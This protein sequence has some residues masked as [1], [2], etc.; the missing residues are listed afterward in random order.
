MKN[1]FYF[2]VAIIILIVVGC[3]QQE[4]SWQEA[5]KTNT[6]MAYSNYLKL[7]S[8]GEHITEAKNLI[9][10]LEWDSAFR[11]KNDSL[12]KYLILKYPNHNNL[13]KTNENIAYLDNLKWKIEHH[14]IDIDS[15]DLLV[16]NSGGRIIAFDG[17]AI[18]F[19]GP[20]SYVK[21]HNIE[22]ACR[23]KGF[24]KVLIWRDFSSD[25][26]A[27]AKKNGL[28]TGVAYLQ[29]VP[30]RYLPIRKVDLKKS[31]KELIKEF[32]LPISNPNN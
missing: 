9:E 15:A 5:K 6:I 10:K 12:L 13:K 16:I 30:G 2:L 24:R 8:Q 27:G 28:E 17:Q 25:E 19:Y 1:L 32:G 14:A 21:E 29:V 18:T 31:D 23:I 20:E 11:E 3:S 7:F 4:S 26:N 22:K